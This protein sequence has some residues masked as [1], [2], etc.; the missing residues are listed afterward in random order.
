MEWKK[1]EDG[2]EG[3]A[4]D[5]VLIATATEVLGVLTDTD[6]NIVRVARP[7][8]PAEVTYFLDAPD[9]PLY[10]LVLRPLPA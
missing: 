4:T 6:E 2:I 9:P 7:G 3:T 1:I 10:W 8:T 5:L